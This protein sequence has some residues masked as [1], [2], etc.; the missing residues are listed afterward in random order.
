[1][2]VLI[3]TRDT[4][5]DVPG[6][7]CWTVEGELVRILADEC[8][9]PDRC[10]CGRGFPGLASSRATTTVR[11][12]ERPMALEDLTRA[13]RDTLGRE[14]WLSGLD[15]TEC[16]A[17]VAEHAAAILAATASFDVGTILRREGTYVM[18][19]TARP[20][21][22]ESLMARSPA[23]GPGTARALTALPPIRGAARSKDRRPP[24]TPR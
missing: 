3:A 8:R 13:L 11:V 20:P 17:A 10:G 16:A 22:F 9:S 24:T 23:C 6:D 15:P 5:G 1:M 4:Q 12:V 19:G 7:Y 2:K 14:G 18:A 21:T